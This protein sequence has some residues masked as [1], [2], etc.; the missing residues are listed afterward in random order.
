[1]H[2]PPAAFLRVNPGRAARRAGPGRPRPRS[3]RG[4]V[5]RAEAGERLREGPACFHRALPG[6]SAGLGAGD[7]PPRGSGAPSL[8][9]RGDSSAPAG[10]TPARPV[11]CLRTCC[12]P[13]SGGAGDFVVGHVLALGARGTCPGKRQLCR[14]LHAPSRGGVEFPLPAVQVSP[15]S[16]N[17]LGNS[18]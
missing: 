7:S 6:G 12:G 9:P 10:R 15:A 4:S 18:L 1:M 8:Q 11:L 17:I 16:L 14:C 2:I 3:R 13:A 5:R